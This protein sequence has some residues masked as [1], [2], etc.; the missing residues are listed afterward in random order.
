MTGMTAR[1]LRIADR[2]RLRVGAMADVVV[3]DPR[4]I[5]DTA[6]Y[7]RPKSAS[8][9]IERVFVN[10]ACAFRGGEEEP[11]VRARAGRMLARAV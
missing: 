4:T 1:N 7:D 8:V 6:T 3:F 5:A 9:G 11:A 2:G 10:G